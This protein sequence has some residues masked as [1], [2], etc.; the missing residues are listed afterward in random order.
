MLLNF[1]VHGKVKK[2]L[3]HTV[4]SVCIMVMSF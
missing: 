2:D 4:K 3:Y 1:S